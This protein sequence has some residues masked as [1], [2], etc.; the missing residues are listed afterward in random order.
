MKERTKFVLEWEQLW[1]E[2][3]GRV[4]MTELCRKYGISRPQGYLWV[5]RYRDG[6]WDIAVVVEKSRRPHRSPTQVSAETEARIVAERKR[7]PRWGPRKL[8]RWM[9]ERHPKKRVPSSSTIGAVLDRAGLTARRG[10]RRR[11]APIP[12]VVTPFASCRGA[13]ATW[14]IDFKGKFQT[15]DGRWCHVLTL[16]DAYT[17]FLLRCEVV[18]DPDSFEV[19]RVLRSAFA[20]YGLPDCI[21][22]DNGPPFASTGAGT[23]TQLSVGWLR[24]GLRVE[25]IAKGRPDQNGRLERLHRSLEEVIAEPAQD[26]RAQQRRFDRWRREYNH[27]RP[28][29]ALGM[30][31]PA[32]LYAP[33]VKQYPRPLLQNEPA[34]WNRSLIVDDHGN[35]NW[36]RRKRV[37]T[38]A[39]LAREVVEVERLGPTRVAVRFGAVLLG[40][41]D[42][43]RLQDGLVVANQRA[44][45]KILTLAFVAPD[46][47]RGK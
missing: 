4:N 17:R 38:S 43:E 18:R 30:R 40:W 28:H 37:H 25:R 10:R 29:E 44:K 32:S 21:R 16:V 45:G 15:L 13:N 19:D 36:H 22:S 33:S 2:N 27:E 42:E 39:S 20:E 46:E 31:T 7:H 14:C 41:I 35:I 3:E 34:A 26:A 23:L 5:K 12:G 6:G 9:L 11:G 1:K 8:R 47:R 24:L